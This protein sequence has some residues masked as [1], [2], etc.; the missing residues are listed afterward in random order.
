MFP[1]GLSSRGLLITKVFLQDGQVT[2]TG[3]SGSLSFNIFLLNPQ[4]G[5]VISISVIN[6][7]KTCSFSVFDPI[8]HIPTEFHYHWS[9]NDYS[10]KGI[11]YAQ[12][13]HS[14]TKKAHCFD[15]LFP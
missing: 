8:K 11:F 2:F 15:H 13:W 5:H 10:L 3:L 12:K 6:P 1:D 7:P 14:K 4:L 9:N